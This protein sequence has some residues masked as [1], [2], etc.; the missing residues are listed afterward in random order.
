MEMN[1]PMIKYFFTL[2]LL[3]LNISIVQ[4]VPD[5]P[6]LIPGKTSL[7]QRVLSIPGAQ[8]AAIPGDTNGSDVTPFTSF[9][10]YQRDNRNEVDWLL[11][12]TDRHGRKDGWIQ[13]NNTLQWD[14]GLTVVFRDPTGHNRSLLFKNKAAL[15]QLSTNKDATAYQALYEQAVTNNLPENSPVVAIQPAGHIDVQKDFYLVPIRDHEDIYLGNEQARM[16]QIASVPLQL[17]PSP[18]LEQNIDETPSPTRQDY[19]SGIVFVIDST[20]SMDTYIDRTREAVMKIYDQLGDSGLLGNVNFGLVAFRDNL[21][22][23]PGLDYV[24]RTFVTLEQGRDPGLFIDKVNN[25]AAATSSSKGFKEDAYAGVQ[26]AIEQMDWEGHDARYIVLITDAGAREGGDSLSNTGLRT[27]QIRQLAID[28]GIAIFVLH[29]LT[30]AQM[31]DH[32]ADARQ[33]TRLSE[34][35]GVGSLYYGVSTGDI[36]EF[37]L[38]LDSLAAQITEQVRLTV[39]PDTSEPPKPELEPPP[40]EDNPQL[41]AL[42]AKVAKLGY[43]LR[44]QYLQKT[45]GQPPR[46]FDAWVLDRD[47]GQPERSTLEVRVLLSRDQLSD[48]HDV[49]QQVLATAEEGLLSPQ[50]F[51][52]ELKSLAATISRNPEDL[53]STTATTAG[54]GNSLAD[55]GFIAEYTEDLPYTSEVINLS[56][57]DWQSWPARQQIMFINSLEEKISYYRALHDHTDLWT[58]LDQGPIDG[59][60]VFPLPLEMLP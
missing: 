38:V 12:G 15:K 4:A 39:N 1:S 17:Q 21:E 25:L 8:L 46:V 10:V 60:A 14:Q 35:P 18:Q 57:E 56:L 33:Y 52:N 3:L 49:L 5:R 9:Y 20:L 55:M 50:N 30:E 23:S 34:F 51:L 37:G 44:M 41:A 13:A 45:D 48:L 36:N 19:T 2:C 43:T 31:A 6:L 22:A 42:Q 28:K 16:L 59:D 29:L 32:E 58:A 54:Q 40:V 11:V 26:Q 53:G 47:I 7:Y 27:E 24:S